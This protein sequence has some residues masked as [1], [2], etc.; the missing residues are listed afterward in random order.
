MTAATCLFCAMAAGDAPV[1]V[2]HDD[3]KVLAFM[4]LRQA[5]PG[6]VLVVPRQHVPD[7]H[8]LDDRERAAEPKDSK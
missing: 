8:A 4:D 6:H 1:S 5:V 2:I 3:G 7:I